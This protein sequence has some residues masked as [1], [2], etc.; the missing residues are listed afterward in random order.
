MERTLVMY[1]VCYSSP[2]WAWE[3]LDTAKPTREEAEQELRE[4]KP[5]YPTAYV[6]R[7]VWSRC[8]A[9]PASR[10]LKAV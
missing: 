2:E 10:P 1:Q 7:V 3:T 8:D 5:R 9:S 6:V 4:V